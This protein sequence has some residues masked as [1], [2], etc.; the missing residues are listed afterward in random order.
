VHYH[1]KASVPPLQQLSFHT[2]ETILIELARHKLQDK[3][4]LLLEIEAK[5]QKEL[6]ELQAL[7]A[8][9]LAERLRVTL[10][11]CFLVTWSTFALCSA[12]VA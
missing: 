3:Q 4:A 10:C 1:A 6:A 7:L 8:A 5:Y 11:V 12:R 2:Q 9:E